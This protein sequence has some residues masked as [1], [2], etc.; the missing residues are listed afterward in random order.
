MLGSTVG[1]GSGTTLAM[2]GGGL[3]GGY[4]GS[5]I[6][7]ANATELTVALDNGGHIVAVVKGKHIE[8]GDRVKIIK[9]GNKA[10]EVS[11]IN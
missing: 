10:S 9:D 7:K 5:E 1:K 2:L 11:K 3:A 4:A 8:V 6:G